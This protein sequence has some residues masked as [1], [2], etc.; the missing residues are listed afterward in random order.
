[1][2]RLTGILICCNY[3]HQA[4]GSQLNIKQAQEVLAEATIFMATGGAPASVMDT[5]A[6]SIPNM[7]TSS[8]HIDEEDTHAAKKSGSSDEIHSIKTEKEKSIGD[9][10]VDAGMDLSYK[11][12]IDPAW[13][14]CSLLEDDAMFVF[15][16]ETAPSSN[17]ALVKKVTE[18]INT[19]LEGVMSVEIGLR[20]DSIHSRVGKFQTV[21]KIT[22]RKPNGEEV[23]ECYRIPYEI[24]DVDECSM[25]LG[26]EWRHNCHPTAQCV[27]TIGSYECACAKGKWGVSGSGQVN[28][29]TG[30]TAMFAR[31]ARQGRCGGEHDTSKCCLGLICDGDA[32]QCQ[33][34]CKASFRCTNDVCAEANCPKNSTC[35]PTSTNSGYGEYECKCNKGFVWDESEGA[36]IIEVKVVIDPCARNACPKNCKCNPSPPNAYS[37]LPKADYVAYTDPSMLPVPTGGLYERLDNTTAC[38]SKH[39]PSIV[40]NGEQPLRAV[41]GDTY[42]E[43]GVTVLD[44]NEEDNE[45]TV[46]IKYSDPFG[47]FFEHVGHYH[48]LYSVEV[49]WLPTSTVV[50][51]ARRD[52]IVTDIDECT[53]TG[54]HDVLR[55]KCVKEATCLNTDGS[56]K[57]LCSEGYTGDGLSNS[58]GCID[59]QPPE[60]QCHGKGCS[61][62]ML[63]AFNSGGIITQNGGPAHEFHDSLNAEF[64][65]AYIKSLGANLCKGCFTAA[66]R[67]FD[68]IVNLTAN[69]TQGPLERH[70]LTPSQNVTADVTDN[71]T[72]K[73]STLAPGSDS[74]ASDFDDFVWRVP[75]SV[76]D[77]AGNS[78]TAYYIIKAEAADVMSA[79]QNVSVHPTLYKQAQLFTVVFGLALMGLILMLAKRSTRA[80]VQAARYLIN[81][82]SLLENK[83]DF[84]VGYDLVLR[85]KSFGRM[86]QR[87]RNR[88]SAARWAQLLEELEDAT[89]EAEATEDILKELASNH[90]NNANTNANNS[91][92]SVN[93]IVNNEHDVEDSDNISESEVIPG[94]G[95]GVDSP[96]QGGTPVRRR[97]YGGV[98]TSRRSQRKA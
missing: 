84:D 69:I 40:L 18:M 70:S 32:K 16:Q 27:N 85:L 68:G 37:C 66:D 57:C 86:S 25:P 53:Y 50:P 67:T 75:F 3:L 36:C 72:D 59:I 78:Q 81:P 17:N 39:V 58:T 97:A 8:S 31:L 54:P 52:V 89:D 33:K 51:P 34:Q 92:N 47:P 62:L 5:P 2:L 6:S 19:R 83:Q 82:F 55:H 35:T 48:V 71:V 7:S 45:R 12:A 88:T 9:I 91:D 77:A 96:A 65:E 23:D 11:G 20:G 93:G 15:S 4:R 10:A 95:G 56:Y 28:T 1:M 24:T 63:K 74:A 73:S 38:L 49:P 44:Q 42:E 30:V 79:L 29:P 43:V 46:K 80:V 94:G 64:I 98:S 90:N 13:E 14:H 61:P 60:I 21:A 41:Q 22:R 87:D 76:T 26:H